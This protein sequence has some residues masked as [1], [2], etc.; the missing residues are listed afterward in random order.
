[1]VD[2]Y[3]PRMGDLSLIKHLTQDVRVGNIPIVVISPLPNDQSQ[4]LVQGAGV[5]DVLSRPFRLKDLLGTIRKN[6]PVRGEPLDETI[7]H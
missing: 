4:Q 3:L 7:V 6:L 5:Q 2:L 1:M